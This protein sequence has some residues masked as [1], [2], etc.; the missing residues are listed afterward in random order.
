MARTVTSIRV[1]QELWKKAKH[2]AIDNEL[3]LTELVEKALK[4]EITQAS[5][6]YKDD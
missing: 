1:D 5:L 6:N 2:H 4:R 3:T